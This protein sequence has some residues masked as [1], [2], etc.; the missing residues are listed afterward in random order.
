MSA[1]FAARQAGQ[2]AV[3]DGER[4][5]LALA[6]VL[7]NHPDVVPREMGWI[8]AL[9]VTPKFAGKG[10]G[11][12]L[13]EWA[14]DW[15]REQGRAL[16]RLGGS[17]CQFAPGVASEWNTPFFRTR[18]YLPR[19]YDSVVQDFALD[20]QN[21][22]SPSPLRAS[23]VVCRPATENDITSLRAFLTREFP[24]RWLYE[25]EQHV[26]ERARIADYLLLESERGIDAC[27]LMT[28]ED[29]LRPVERYYPS[30]MPRPWGQVGSVGVSADRRNL[31]YG[32][33]LLDATLKLM[34]ASGVRGCIID[35]TGLVGYYER[36]GFRAWRKYEML[37][38]R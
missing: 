37:V 14:E 9:C 33:A 21:Y 10:I 32:S 28:V 22:T 30:P 16:F 19:P 3:V 27:C 1:P 8:D 18:G 13:L 5:G 17:L 4:V 2:F 26:R 35:W 6:S 12:K 7:D 11:S 34:R 31:G 20:L 38:K 15:L 24:G 36:F 23:K 25:L 29:S